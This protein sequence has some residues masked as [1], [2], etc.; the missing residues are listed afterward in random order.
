MKIMTRKLVDFFYYYCRIFRDGNSMNVLECYYQL[1]SVV[2]PQDPSCFIII[3]IKIRRI[4]L[5]RQIRQMYKEEKA[6]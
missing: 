6:R 3:I 2:K 4:F 1:C 5:S